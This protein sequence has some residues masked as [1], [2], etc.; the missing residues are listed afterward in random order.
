[1]GFEPMTPTLARWRSTTELRPHLRQGLPCGPAIVMRPGLTEG[2]ETGA[3]DRNRTDDILIG[4]QTLYQLSYARM[5]WRTPV[6]QVFAIPVESAEM[7]RA[8]SRVSI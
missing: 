5:G 3:G 1:M 2:R 4:N 6:R 7:A 8:T